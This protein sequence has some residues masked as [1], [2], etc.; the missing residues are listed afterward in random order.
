MTKRVISF[1]LACLLVFAFA[2]CR[3]NPE[4]PGS[5]VI[6]EYDYVYETESGSGDGE[7]EAN[8]DELSGG[9]GNAA[10]KEDGK[11]SQ[12]QTNNGSSGSGG[13]KGSN[14]QASNGTTNTQTQTNSGTTNLEGNTY[15][16]G[17][18]IVKNK[19][20]I[21]VMSI[22]RADVGDVSKSQFNKTYASL[23]NIDVTW[24]LA[25]ENEAGQRKTL[26]LQSG[27]LPDIITYGDSYVS[28]AE[29]LQYSGEGAFV[30]I[31]KDMLKK[32]APNIYKTYD[33]Y[34]AW[35][36]VKMPDGKMY[37]IAGFTKDYPYGQHIIWV[38]TTWLKKLGI[39]TPKTMDEF[40]EM[41]KKF[42][43]ND[44]N[45]NGQKDEVP[46]AT[47]S[48][49]GFV[50]NPWGFNSTM[51]LT[52]GGKVVCTWTTSNMKNALTYWN[53][54]YKEG[55]V[56]T[57]TI[58]NYS[59]NY[60]AFKTLLAGGKVGAFY[61][62]WPND[63]MDDKLLKEYEPLVW[64][65]AGNNGDFPSAHVDTAALINK[66]SF[67]ITKACKNV[68]A[69]LRWLDYLYT[70]DGYMLKVYG[71]EGGV[72]KKTSDK[73]YVNNTAYKGDSKTVLGPAWTLTGRNFLVDA[74]YDG[75]KG[76]LLVEKRNS[77]NDKLA[78]LMKSSGQK[79]M[80]T[81]FQNKNEIQQ[82]KLYS[83]YFS[84]LHSKQFEFIK[85]TLNL[86]SD[87]T[88][89][90]NEIASKGLDKYTKIL[91]SYYDRCN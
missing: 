2:G 36:D 10:Q 87:Y 60:A 39:S 89:L 9:S 71:N 12:N 25:T 5:S 27:N 42:K 48:S 74:T 73:T 90:Q 33:E 41:L 30:E 78:S 19:E 81:N 50:T 32:W 82:M 57:K 26:A 79:N 54:V 20:K 34:N 3:K 4:D 43:N 91:Q 22:T 85:G 18:P 70:N 45:G 24:D 77:N 64:P 63:S 6:V 23:T 86:N 56:D 58:D 53:K 88:A 8:S 38:R 37:S 40:Y 75:E 1:L 51:G 29:M 35:D 14:T 83:S 69:A 59:G 66:T 21:K 49:V 76:S 16:S 72:Y 31:T 47:F 52:T 84:T 80:P 67:I 55:L 62:G 28:S 11:G 46:Y 17:F 7:T 65:T 44:P 68:P 13:N 15:K 61:Y